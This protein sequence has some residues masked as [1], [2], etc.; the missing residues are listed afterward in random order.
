M[1]R[2]CETCGSLLIPQ[3]KDDG[4]V[5]LYCKVC[6]TESEEFTE[7]SYQ[8]KSKIQHSEEDLLTVIDDPEDFDIRPTTR[9]ACP[10]RCN[11]YE[12]RYWEAENRKKEEWETTTYYKCTSCEWVWS[13]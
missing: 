7:D 4:K 10:R 11:H 6:N 3:R 13:E 12:A 8:V 2:F 9:I 5:T 1:V